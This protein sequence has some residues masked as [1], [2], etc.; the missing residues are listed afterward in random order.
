LTGLAGHR[1]QTVGL[2]PSYITFTFTNV[3][4]VRIWK[5]DDLCRRDE[6]ILFSV[7]LFDQPMAGG[8]WGFRH[9]C[10]RFLP[11]RAFTEFQR[12]TVEI[13]LYWTS[14]NDARR[15]YIGDDSEQLLA[16]NMDGWAVCQTRSAY[17]HYSPTVVAT[18]RGEIKIILCTILLLLLSS[19]IIVIVYV[20]GTV[21]RAL[22]LYSNYCDRRAIERMRA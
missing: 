6:R 22:R 9:S 4:K 21:T 17:K 14:A 2:I 1:R 7:Y 3:S 11:R 8:C 13:M 16:F 18:S 20:D 19:I 5:A 12:P 10:R 15:T